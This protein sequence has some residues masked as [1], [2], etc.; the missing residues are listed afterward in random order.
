MLLPNYELVAR[1]GE[2]RR[3]VI[4]E[5]YTKR[6]PRRMLA[7][8]LL[9]APLSES[10]KAYFI[11]RIERLK[12]LKDPLVLVPT[13]F[14]TNAGIFYMGQEYFD[15][16]PLDRLI[17]EKQQL[18][19]KDFFSIACGI[20]RALCGIHEAGIVHGGIKPHNVLVNRETLESASSTWSAPL[21]YPT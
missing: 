16:V 1:I 2:S 21:M 13:E 14:G 7:L 10:R 12:V 18:S 15:G 17:L 5:G 6:K 3:A 8:K 9:K 4:Y 11:Q 20:V 19:L